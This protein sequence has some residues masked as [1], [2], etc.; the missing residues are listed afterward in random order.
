VGLVL[1]SVRAL[2]AGVDEMIRRLPEFQAGVRRIDN[3]AVFELPEILAGLT[4]PPPPGL[5]RCQ[6]R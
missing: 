1:R 6:P 3:R 4:R 2:P 5:S